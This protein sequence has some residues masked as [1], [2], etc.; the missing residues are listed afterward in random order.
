MQRN[1][2]NSVS[3][4]RL[5]FLRDIPTILWSLVHAVMIRTFS[6][7]KPDC[8]AGR[9]ESSLRPMNNN[10]IISYHLRV[11]STPLR[12]DTVETSR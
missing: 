3:Y 10:I 4:L 1:H 6:Y 9:F 2:G 5:V 11:E 8:V 12:E 7:Y